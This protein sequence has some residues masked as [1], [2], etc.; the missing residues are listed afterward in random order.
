MSTSA[1]H[2]DRAGVNTCL[3]AYWQ[4]TT[5]KVG[6]VCTHSSGG[7]SWCFLK[8]YPRCHLLRFLICTPFLGLGAPGV[9]TTRFTVCFLCYYC[10]VASPFCCY[11][12]GLCS[13]GQ[14]SGVVLF[15]Q[16]GF[17]AVHSGPSVLQD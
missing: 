5:E 17:G 13:E 10:K 2:L 11:S 1:L 3:N 16:Q 8:A 4:L 6:S 14:H 9:Q 15:L 7:C 12:G